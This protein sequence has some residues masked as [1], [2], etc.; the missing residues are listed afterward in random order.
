MAHELVPHFVCKRNHL[1][2]ILFTIFLLKI[3]LFIRVRC[4]IYVQRMVPRDKYDS[5]CLRQYRFD[6]CNNYD[7]EHRMTKTQN[8]K[9]IHYGQDQK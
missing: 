9:K 5:E 6:L 7:A 3:S 4:L 2:H 8:R 1:K